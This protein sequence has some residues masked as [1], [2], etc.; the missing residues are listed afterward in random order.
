MVMAML[1]VYLDCVH[2][3]TYFVSYDGLLIAFANNSNAAAHI[4]WVNAP[5]AYDGFVIT[6]L[7]SLK[8]GVVD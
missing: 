4:A 2:T 8:F 3:L 6:S 1:V 5:F 7:L